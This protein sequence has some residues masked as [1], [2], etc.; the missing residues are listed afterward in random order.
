MQKNFKISAVKFYSLFILILGVFFF[1]CKRN[2]PQQEQSRN[3]EVSDEEL[4]EMNRF[5]I[6]KDAEIIEKYA[7][8]R[9]W[10]MQETKTGLWYMIYEHGTGAP[11][12]KGKEATVLYQLELLDGTVCYSSDSLGPKQFRIGR[13]GIESGLEEGI[14]LMQEGDKA[15]FILP[16]HRAHGLLG[17]DNKI[18]ARATLVY[19][20]TLV[21]VKDINN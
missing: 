1:S 12:I 10:E 17:D 5:L 7:E 6:K 2:V 14:L 11:A 8:R 20:I 4:M 16:P 15:R 21:D 18:P 19:D 9:N 3:K 13:G